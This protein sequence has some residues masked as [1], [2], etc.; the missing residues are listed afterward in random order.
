MNLKPIFARPMFSLLLVNLL[1][2]ICA[3]RD[4]LDPEST[5]YKIFK[6]TQEN[7]VAMLKE[8]SKLPDFQAN[9]NE[10]I[11]PSGQ[12]PLMRA[13]L[14]GQ[15]PDTIRTLLSLG[16][17]PA[18]AEKD[19][20]TPMHGVGFQG[21]FEL[22]PVLVNEFGL[23]PNDKHA[24]G[25]TPLH[26]ACWGP[27]ERHAKTVEV[28]LKLGADP[29]EPMCRDASNCKLPVDATTNQATKIILQKFMTKTENKEGEL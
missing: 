25:F 12:T 20:Y 23:D 7:Q 5:L 28:L 8:L 15:A 29:N 24:D 10:T 14:M 13:V 1:Q 9:I 17:D 22:A 16:A 11:D 6:Y 19:G 2:Y 26:R 3:T 18:I 27:D 21:R 4:Q